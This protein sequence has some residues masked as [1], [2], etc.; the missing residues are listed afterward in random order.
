MD[1]PTKP[2][3]IGAPPAFSCDQCGRDINCAYIDDRLL[4]GRCRRE[5]CAALYRTESHSRLLWRIPK[6]KKKG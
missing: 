4:C 5:F 1:D 3:S 2:R 6:R